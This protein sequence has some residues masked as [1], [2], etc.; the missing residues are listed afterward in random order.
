[1]AGYKRILLVED[2][3]VF[4]QIVARNLR[5][6]GC[7][8]IEAE[9]AR[10]GLARLKEDLPDLLLLDINLP[11]RSGWDI[12][13]QMQLRGTQVPTIIVSAVRVSEERLAEF[14]PKAYLPKPFPLE[15]LLRIVEDGEPAEVEAGEA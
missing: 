11:D 3:P 8:V 1:M 2:E 13:R 6:R 15:A 10:E 5:A 12:L 9:T 7:E 4:R 14:K